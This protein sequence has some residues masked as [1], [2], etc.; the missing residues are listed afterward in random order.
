MKTLLYVPIIHTSADLGSLA[1]AVT[2]RGI[3]ALGGDVWGQH[4][5]TVEKFWDVLSD[6]FTAIDAAG[7]KVYQD[8]MPADGE[9]GAKIVEEGA[10]SGS[11]NYELIARLLKRGA[12]L[13]KTENFGLV[14]QER[15]RLAAL[16]RAKSP[17]QKLAAYIKYKWVKG[18]L[19]TKRDDFIAKKINETLGDGQTGIIFIGAAHNIKK[20]LPPDIRIIEIK[21]AGKVKEYQELL[22]FYH[23]N[24]ER[25]A[26][27]AQYLAARIKT[28]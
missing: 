4:Q 15:D 13:I 2:K 28:G 6:Y 18:R 8:G 26:E 20:R 11:R 23:G 12:V 21:D 14:K 1:K 3:D 10:K 24:K 19:L 16:T 5:A 17:L 9:L 27:L 22:P 7:I 25:F